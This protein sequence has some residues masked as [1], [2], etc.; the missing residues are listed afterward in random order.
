MRRVRIAYRSQQAIESEPP[1]PVERP[2][3]DC[4]V[5]MLPHAA[6]SSQKEPEPLPHVVAELVELPSGVPCPNVVP[7][8]PQ[9]RIQASDYFSHVFHPAAPRVGEFPNASPYS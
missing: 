8:A 5:P 3:G 7:P 1:K 6:A 9:D 4:S 2:A